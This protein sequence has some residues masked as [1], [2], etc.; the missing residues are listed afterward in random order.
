MKI[1]GKNEK[2]ERKTEENYKAPPAEN[3]L[4]EGIKVNLQRREMGND[5]NAQY[6]PLSTFGPSLYFIYIF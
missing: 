2:R 6:I 4:V 3:L 5:R 1:R